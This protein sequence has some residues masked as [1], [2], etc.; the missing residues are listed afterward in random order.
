VLEFLFEDLNGEEISVKIYGN[1]I[2]GVLKT[3]EGKSDL[4]STLFDTEKDGDRI[5]INGKGFGHGV[6][7][8]QWGAIHLSKEGWNYEDILEHYFPGTSIGKLND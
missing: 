5:I 1:D 4:W 2:R 3:G 8:C 6:G 7:L